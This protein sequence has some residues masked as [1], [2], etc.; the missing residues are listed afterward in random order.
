M[1]SESGNSAEVDCNVSKTESESLNESDNAEIVP[2]AVEVYTVDAVISRE[3]IVNKYS[4]SD[5]K[6]TLQDEHLLESDVEKKCLGSIIIFEP[7]EIKSSDRP[8]SNFKAQERLSKQNSGCGQTIV[9]ANPAAEISKLAP[10]ELHAK[11]SV[12]EVDCSQLDDSSVKNG[13]MGSTVLETE[14]PNYYLDKLNSQDVAFKELITAN[15]LSSSPQL[16][17]TSICDDQLCSEIQIGQGSIDGTCEL[18]A[19]TA[20]ALDSL[21]VQSSGLPKNSLELEGDGIMDSIA[22]VITSGSAQNSSSVPKKKAKRQTK[23]GK[24]TDTSFAQMKIA[25]VRLKKSN[26]LTT[27]ITSECC[28]SQRS[29]LSLNSSVSCGKVENGDS[30]VAQN[31]SHN[32]KLNIGKKMNDA[33]GGRVSTSLSKK[34][35]KQIISDAAVSSN[36][37]ST[38]PKRKYVRKS[39]K[40]ESVDAK[41]ESNNV[42]ASICDADVLNHIFSNVIDKSS[43]E[44][45]DS[46]VSAI[47]PKS[48]EAYEGNSKLESSRAVKVCR[49]CDMPAECYVLCSGP[50]LGVFHATCIGT[51]AD[52]NELYRCAECTTGNDLYSF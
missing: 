48:E 11:C 31:D 34:A 24:Q 35:V 27:M 13:T 15:K 5:I 40:T 4:D 44:A 23:T 21:P 29:E 36:N 46:V 17:A 49:V 30:S 2:A 20:A 3:D 16:Q 10:P 33:I 14:S 38:V 28:E 51:S 47:E 8:K 50:C 18:L 43:S 12:T 41:S 6:L 22:N 9:E 25:V 32:T 19:Q 1:S 42:N 39:L 7:V 37:A 52:A 26:Q 45:M